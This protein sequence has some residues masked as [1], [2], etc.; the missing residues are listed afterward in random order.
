MKRNFSISKFLL[1]CTT[2]L[3]SILSSCNNQVSKSD[4]HT[5]TFSETYSYD[6]E[7]HWKECTV[8][9]CTEISEKEAHIYDGDSDS[10]CNICGYVR[11]GKEN[12]I[13]FTIA[14]RTYNQKS[15]G[16]ILGKDFSVEYGTP[17]V[18][19][20]KADEDND[21]YTLEEPIKAGEYTVKV[22]VEGD[23][24]YKTTF[25]KKNFEIKPIELTNLNF[26]KEFD[27][28]N[29]IIV[30]LD[31]T[32][33][34]LEG[35]NV[36]INI[37]LNDENVGQKSIVSLKWDNPNY[38]VPLSKVACNITKRINT[39]KI[40][41]ASIY[42]GIIYK[43]DS[44]PDPNLENTGAPSGT[45]FEVKYFKYENN[46]TLKEVVLKDVT[47]E[48][49]RYRIEIVNKTEYPNDVYQFVKD[50]EV[51]DNE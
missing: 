1:L 38:D 5:H 44:L 47:K 45:E 33:G 14:E 15:Q 36:S 31:D 51:K 40:E 26:V 2:P 8:D 27:G 10:D 29:H 12:K 6:N 50:F 4:V 22:V 28:N 9:K 34:V 43:G 35:D 23:S 13:A 19:Y 46:G 24:L 21:K 17:I 25:A 32:N 18:S 39:I 37:R 30:T 7:F 16:L 48:S 49:G 3:I 11:V 41:N 20:K 42:D